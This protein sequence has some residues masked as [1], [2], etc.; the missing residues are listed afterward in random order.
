MPKFLALLCGVGLALGA[1]AG[2]LD[3]DPTP[4]ELKFKVS[5][6]PSPLPDPGVG[7]LVLEINVPTGFHVFSDETLSVNMPSLKGVTWGVPK[8][9]KGE[10]EEDRPVLR[11][12]LRI[13]IPVDL[14]RD[15]P[16]AVRGT[17]ELRWQAC[18]EFGDKVCF[19][20]IKDAVPFDLAVKSAPGTALAVAPAE[21]PATLPAP[22]AAP[23]PAGE[24]YIPVP[25]RGQTPTPAVSPTA[26]K[27]E[28]YEARFAKAA[29]E[30]VPLA[31]LLAFLFG[32]LSSLTPCVYPVIPI[33]VAY[34]GSRSEG[35]GRSAGFFLSLAFVAGLALV[36]AVLGAVSA[37][38]G[39][40][41]GA[42]TQTPWVG[43][44]IAALF[45]ALSL[46]MFNLFEFKTPAALTNRIE[47]TKR[48]GKGRGFVGAFLI[49]A[50][51][52]LVASPCIGPLILA[53]LVVV[54]ATGSVALGFL[55]LFVYAL[56]LGVL[57]IV[58][59]TFSGV[60]AS[61]PKSGGWMDGVRVLFGALILAA[62]FYFA[63]LYLPKTAF[64]VVGL[65]ALWAVVL[66]LLFGAKRHFFGLPMRVA[67]I[68]LCALAFVAVLSLLPSMARGTED[69]VAWQ[70]SLDAGLAAAKAQGKPAL[71]DMRADWC[72][73]C[74]ELEKKTWPDAGVQKW[75]G[76][77]VPIRLD[78][79][80]NTDADQAIMQRYG[81]KGLPTVLLLS[82]EGQV[83]SGFVGYRSPEAVLGW[84]EAAK[85]E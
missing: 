75:L 72:V 20:P 50:L 34:I 8:V 29:R 9:P 31:L 51:S 3:S 21:P 2:P 44:P 36:Y 61:M 27:A 46:S 38:A 42:L 57:F 60:L 53:I 25:A 19:L 23:E 52:G 70:S 12:A 73:A 40:A 54:A 77:V 67:G 5:T 76:T 39:Q 74:V 22:S 13:E 84:A 37:K 26:P 33:T 6:V 47:A 15:A 28:G 41:F 35:K 66:F 59:G 14:T 85:K 71:L 48:K 69:G 58:I 45:F 62:A 16:A 63:G 4:P 49:G 24:G 10:M 32:V 56:G 17:L 1:W 78:M 64:L 81:V 55:Y 80:K 7:H 30:N 82:S 18:Q 43:L 65:L 83:I 79:T 68:L 11:G